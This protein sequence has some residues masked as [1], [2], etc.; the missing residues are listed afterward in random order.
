MCRV[1]Y[2]GV[3]N[4]SNINHMI[5]TPPTHPMPT[6]EGKYCARNTRKVECTSD[7]SGLL[8]YQTRNA[9]FNSCRLSLMCYMIPTLNEQQWTDGVWRW[10]NFEFDHESGYSLAIYFIGL[11]NPWIDVNQQSASTICGKSQST[12]CK[13]SLWCNWCTLHVHAMSQFV[14]MG[15][16][17]RMA[18]WLWLILFIFNS[19]LSTIYT[20][21][22]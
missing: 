1:A 20:L 7:V 11:M 3:V 22:P 14:K 19:L 10:P 17:K 8:D 2:G 13:H 6:H 9:T 21:E 12:E 16:N 18:G 5:D 15:H 4:I